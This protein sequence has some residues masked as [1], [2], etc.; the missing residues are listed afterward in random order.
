MACA[1]TCPWR[2]AQKE[3]VAQTYHELA[4][5]VADGTL[6]APVEATYALADY[7]EAIAHA[8]RNDRN[9][10]VLFALR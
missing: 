10:K 1:R 2:W 8:A 9:G 4:T 7:R 6:A 5:L 3:S